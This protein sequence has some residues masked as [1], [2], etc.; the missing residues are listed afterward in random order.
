MQENSSNGYA[1]AT[2]G[3]VYRQEEQKRKSE[4]MNQAGAVLRGSDRE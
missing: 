4:V 1:L 2:I 3:Y